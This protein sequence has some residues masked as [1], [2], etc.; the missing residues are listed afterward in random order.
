LGVPGLLLV[1]VGPAVLFKLSGLYLGS[2]WPVLV[3]SVFSDWYHSPDS[4]VYL[5][6]ALIAYSIWMGLGSGCIAEKVSQRFPH[7]RSIA[8]LRIAVLFILRAVLAIPAID[9]PADPTAE[10]YAHL[11][12]GSAPARAILITAGDEETFSLWYFHY[13]YR[14]PP[15]IA[16]VSSDPLVQPWYHGILKPTCLDLVFP[17]EPWVEALM[18]A[19]SGRPVCLPP[20][21]A[22]PQLECTGLWQRRERGIQFEIHLK[23]NLFAVATGCIL[24]SQPAGLPNRDL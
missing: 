14:E 16:V 24:Q 17:V 20:L 15:D 22:Q 18:L 6:P 13:A 8:I 21:M 4:Y 11:I 5:I 1:F 2:A 3:Y 10:R 9:L 19:N 12:L 7:F 23:G